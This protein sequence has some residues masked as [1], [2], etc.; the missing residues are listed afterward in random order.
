MRDGG[1]LPI[2]RGLRP[3]HSGEIHAT[4]NLVGKKRQVKGVEGE[5]EGMGIK[6]KRLEEHWNKI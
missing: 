2:C 5:C 6:G 1:E 3:D 4:R